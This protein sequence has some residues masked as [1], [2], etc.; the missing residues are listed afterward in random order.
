MDE[1]LLIAMDDR[2][3]INNVINIFMNDL[4]EPLPNDVDQIRRRN[5]RYKNENYF[6]VVIPRYT[7]IQF[8]EHFRMSTVTFEVI[9][10]AFLNSLPALKIYSSR[11]YR[12]SVLV[13]NFGTQP[14]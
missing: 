8:A 3:N 13:V 11:H 6:E 4:M 1:I 12:I 2:V 9:V 5:E 10:A 7:D 14:V